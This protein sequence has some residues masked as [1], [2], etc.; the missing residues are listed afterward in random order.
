VVVRQLGQIAPHVVEPEP[1][2]AN[3]QQSDQKCM[4]VELRALY[5][6]VP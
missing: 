3:E 4:N 5:I 1:A 2:V 6:A